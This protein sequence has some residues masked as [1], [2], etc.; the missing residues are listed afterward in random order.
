MYFLLSILGDLLFEGLAYVI[1]RI[2]YFFRGIS[3]KKMKGRKYFLFEKSSNI[4]IIIAAV[5]SFLALL[6]FFSR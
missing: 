5:I 4:T 1:K 2:D 3:Y 6:F